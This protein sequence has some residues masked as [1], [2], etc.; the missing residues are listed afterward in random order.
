MSMKAFTARRAREAR[1]RRRSRPADRPIGQCNAKA[2]LAVGFPVRTC[3]CATELCKRE[4]YACQGPIAFR[5]A[6]AKSV[7][8][9]VLCARDPETF[10]ARVLDEFARAREK[11]ITVKYAE[12]AREHSVRI[13]ARF[14]R[15]NASGDLF[16]AARQAILRIARQGVWVHVFTR[17]PREGRA[18]RRAARRENLPILV[19]LSVDATSRPVCFRWSGAFAAL[20]SAAAPAPW[21]RLDPART[22]AFPVDGRPENIAT[23]PEAFRGGACPC[24]M[25]VRS[26]VGSCAQCFADGT[27]CFMH[28]ER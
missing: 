4:C 11:G 9:Y 12:G 8:N 1:A 19:L 14:V 16:P 21:N 3:K 24:D 25:K 28:V 7:E 2:G 23:V 27:G 6:V 5:D 17:D 13:A 10:A 18:L 22:V 15:W 20:T 26:Y